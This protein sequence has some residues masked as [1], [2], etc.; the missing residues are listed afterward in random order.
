MAA[1]SPVNGRAGTDVDASDATFLLVNQLQFGDRFI[2]LGLLKVACA[3][4]AELSRSGMPGRVAILETFDALR[5]R[6]S[7]HR[8]LRRLAELASV[9]RVVGFSDFTFYAMEGLQAMV[10][11]VRAANPRAAI[12]LGG[13]GPTVNTRA[14]QLHLRPD[15]IFLGVHGE[16]LVSIRRALPHLVVFATSPDEARRALRDVP[17][18]VVDGVPTGAATVIDPHDP[19]RWDIERYGL[20][21]RDYTTPAGRDWAF[22][23][24]ATHGEEAGG[25]GATPSII[26][27]YQFFRL[28]CPNH[29]SRDG[30]TFC[31]IA[32]QAARSRT[33]AA[34]LA[35]RFDASSVR[36]ELDELADR[37]A[38]Y[39]P[40]VFVVDDSM[41]AR[42]LREV[43][44]VLESSRLLPLLRGATLFVRPDFVSERFL[45]HLE[46]LTAR[47][48]EVHLFVGFDF[49]SHHVH[50]AARTR[51]RMSAFP[52]VM[53]RLERADG[54]HTVAAFIASHPAM[55][56]ADFAA[57]LAGIK[58]VA[59]G[60]PFR[61]AVA[62]FVFVVDAMAASGEPV[63]VRYRGY[64]IT[65][66]M[67]SVFD[68]EPCPLVEP[69]HMGG[70]DLAESLAIADAV[71][72]ELTTPPLLGHENALVFASFLQVVRDEL[73]RLTGSHERDFTRAHIGAGAAA[74]PGVGDPAL[75]AVDVQLLEALRAALQPV[76]GDGI[77]GLEVAGAEALPS[78]EVRVTL[79][80]TS[81]ADPF[82][83][84]ID[85]AARGRPRFVAVGPWTVSY[86]PKTPPDTPRRRAALRALAFLLS[87]APL[88]PR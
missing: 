75:E 44:D 35:T 63:P 37:M 20:D 49:M 13:F 88:P 55:T 79:I 2:P 32:A 8:F 23:Y 19:V 58:E 83:L 52:A 67:R 34:E 82:V 70:Q 15:A 18:L 48:V 56:P 72:G 73:A 27:P 5:S 28:S 6:E 31:G 16:A 12:V 40:H 69:F 81:E 46:R 41:T 50:E 66:A 80:E 77:G 10:E 22:P 14:Y 38:G 62:P 30:C 64:Y 71:L 36:G 25:D 3:I 33:Y 65:D 78:L 68:R 11:A 24:R 4:E 86:S 9:A 39:A 43:I 1:E 17:G 21:L 26:V 53:D 42:G 29:V 59:F 47:G 76:A 7:F 61:L 84:F 54:V 51:K 85:R 87:R 45:S 57:H 60:R 74:R